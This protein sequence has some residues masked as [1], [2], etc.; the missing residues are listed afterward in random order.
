MKLYAAIDLRGGRC[1]RLRQGDPERETAYGDDPVAVARR[2]EAEGADG[3]HVVDLDGAFAGAPRQT[4]TVAAI[5]RAV[6][7]PVQAGGGLRTLG[8]VADLLAAGAAR[9][10]VGT[11][12]LGRAFL[13]SAVA[14]FGGRLLPALD[15]RDGVVAVAGWR[16]SSGVALA[17]A[18]AMLRAAGCGD[19]LYTDV[20][21]DGMLLGPDLAGLASL[22]EAG[23]AVIAS[24]GVASL[25]DLQALG[26]AGAAGVVIGR[27]LYDGR[28][29]LAAA[30][31]AVRPT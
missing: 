2:W 19:V 7:I 13:D 29:R 30:R 15:A 31:M 23:L 3:L 11:Q 18:A 22:Q 10:V 5:C 1:V 28:L 4:A 8:D 14:R 9:A 25:A 24:G 26:R 17:D 6:H 12:V 27:A 16:Q 21:R 20:G